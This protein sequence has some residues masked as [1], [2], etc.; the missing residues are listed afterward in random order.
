MCVVRIADLNIAHV[1]IAQSATSL[2][3][4][5]TE[6]LSYNKINHLAYKA[7]DRGIVSKAEK[8]MTTFRFVCDHMAG[9]FHSTHIIQLFPSDSIMTW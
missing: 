3:E 1:R 8:N 2:G 6:R 5:H 9:A 4:I 7:A